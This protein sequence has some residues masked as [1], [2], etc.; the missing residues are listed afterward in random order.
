L[1]FV[2]SSIELVA[3]SCNFGIVVSS[4]LLSIFRVQFLQPF[5][6]RVLLHPLMKLFQIPLEMLH[7]D[8][9]KYFSQWNCRLMKEK[10]VER[11]LTS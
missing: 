2:F 6:R 5:W 7:K 9:E 11:K 10:G 1:F 4:K 8:R 3:V